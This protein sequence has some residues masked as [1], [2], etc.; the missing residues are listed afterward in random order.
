MLTSNESPMVLQAA[1]DESEDSQSQVSYLKCCF[2]DLPDRQTALIIVTAVLYFMGVA[3]TGIP[4]TLLINQRIAGDAEDPNAE[5]AFVSATNSFVHSV[6]SFIFGRYTS[7]FGDYVGRKPVLFLS[8]FCFF[9]SRILYIISYTPAGFY[10]A[11]I[12]GGV[13]D[14]YYFS[15]L[16]WIC[17]VFPE[18]SRRSKR[19][20]LFT[21]VV[22]GL[23]FL[24][25]LPLG[26]VLAEVV[27]IQA[28][29]KVSMVLSAL[30]MVSL[31]IL[32]VDDTLGCD[33][34]DGDRIKL[35]GRRSLPATAIG[36]IKSHFPISGGSLNLTMAAKYPADW[37]V[38]FM[39]H[40]TS[41]LLN[42]IFIQYALAV[43]GWSGV[44]AS[45]AYAFVGISL[46]VLAPVV[47]HRYA[48]IPLAFRTMTLFTIGL[49]LLSVSGT[50]MYGAQ[51]VGMAG[52][53]FIAAGTTWVPSLQTNLLSQYG[54]EQQ[55]GVRK[56]VFIER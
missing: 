8:A 13:F 1:A 21:G 11:G 14:C 20:G 44:Q 17:D 40:S 22:G 7:G 33:S 39:M 19:I 29:I 16:A 26:A 10:L 12:V 45:G 47:M 25:G 34:T 52:V 46:A 30:C 56:Q 51:F 53:A 50:G 43:Y 2:K 9:A 54:P 41:S 28:P 27:D 35:S 3:I 36:F 15:A 4:I 6:L 23:A 18:G 48:P 24:I 42:L 55:G 49:W 31:V 32:P 38:N 5:S 37:A